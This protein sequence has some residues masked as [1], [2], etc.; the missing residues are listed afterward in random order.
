MGDSGLSC[1]FTSTDS[2][3]KLRPNNALHATYLPPL[4]Y[5]KSARELGR[6]AKKEAMK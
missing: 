3:V 6:W 1:R 5:G 4:R 2:A